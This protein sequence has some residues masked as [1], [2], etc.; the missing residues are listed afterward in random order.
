MP[1]LYS[2]FHYIIVDVSTIKELVERWLPVQ[3]KG[4]KKKDKGRAIEDIME[5]IEELKFYKKHI[6]DAKG[7]DSGNAG[8]F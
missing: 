1:N 6:F 5:S 4:P 7:S 3:F 2:F 8:W